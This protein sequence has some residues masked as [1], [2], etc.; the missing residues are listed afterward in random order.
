MSWFQTKWNISRTNH[1]NQYFQMKLLYSFWSSFVWDNN[2][3]NNNA[4]TSINVHVFS[5]DHTSPKNQGSILFTTDKAFIHQCPH[6]MGEWESPVTSGMYS[7]DPTS[8]MYL[9]VTSGMY[10]SHMNYI[11]PSVHLHHSFSAES[12]LYLHYRS[13]DA[14]KQDHL[15]QQIYKNM[16]G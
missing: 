7:T 8:G 16:L 4:T 12:Y 11:I 3:F 1:G 2:N 15:K 9:P 5:L 6:T 10:W 13:S 14:A